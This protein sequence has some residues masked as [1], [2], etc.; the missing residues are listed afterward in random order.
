MGALQELPSW[1]SQSHSISAKGWGETS[2]PSQPMKNT[3]PK[4]LAHAVHVIPRQTTEEDKGGATGTE[5]GQICI[6]NLY[7]K[8]I[9]GEFVLCPRL[10]LLGMQSGDRDRIV[11]L[12]KNGYIALWDGN[13]GTCLKTVNNLGNGMHYGIKSIAHPAIKETLIGV[14]GQYHNI[15]ILDPN[16]LEFIC[17]LK[18]SHNPN[19]ISQL[20]E[21]AG[22]ESIIVLS[23]TQAA[24][25]LL[26]AKRKFSKAWSQYYFLRGHKRRVP[27]CCIL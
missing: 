5:T 1:S 26:L 18:S 25:K 9:N 24:P 23:G 3:M 13:D 27:S 10:L 12:S 8:R 21:A 16:T 11:S 19:W 7:R 14:W 22:V 20:M 15:F 2:P 6:L 4:V 17:A